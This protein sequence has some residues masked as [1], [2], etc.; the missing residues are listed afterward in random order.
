MNMVKWDYYAICIYQKSKS[1]LKCSYL[2]VFGF[3]LT[4]CT[5]TACT[6]KCLFKTYSFV[7]IPT[8]VLGLQSVIKPRLQLFGKFDF[9]FCFTKEMEALYFS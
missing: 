5:F 6:R 2:V 3:Q 8:N 7:H 4:V 1:L 9:V